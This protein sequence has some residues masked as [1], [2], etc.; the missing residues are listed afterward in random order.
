MLPIFTDEDSKRRWARETPRGVLKTL[1][2]GIG[3]DV[4]RFAWLPTPFWKP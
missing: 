4:G 1:S 2:I 3:G